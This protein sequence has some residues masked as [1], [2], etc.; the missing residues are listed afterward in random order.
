M[1]KSGFRHSTLLCFRAFKLFLF[2]QSSVLSLMV[3][4]NYNSFP[5][6][7]L[8]N[9]LR[10]SSNFS[11]NQLQLQVVPPTQCLPTSSPKT[12]VL[13]LHSGHSIYLLNSIFGQDKGLRQFPVPSLELCAL[14]SPIDSVSSTF[15][16]ALLNMACVISSSHCPQNLICDT[17][18]AR[19]EQALGG[20][21]EQ[22]CQ[23]VMQV[24]PNFH[25]LPTLPKTMKPT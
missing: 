1:H 18:P 15:Y 3:C 12:R 4:Q 24:D 17:C 6:L 19:L 2:S 20:E 22:T 23:Q 10:M 8:K 11:L 21:M 14:V 25:T 5:K 16:A 7:L 13:P 9:V